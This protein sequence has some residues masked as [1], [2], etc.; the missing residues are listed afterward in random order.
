MC[1]CVCVCVCVCARFYVY[2]C[3]SGQVSYHFLH[4][5]VRIKLK[6]YNQSYYFLRFFSKLYLCFENF[7]INRIQI[8]IALYKYIFLAYSSTFS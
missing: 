2:V 5:I 3:M 6:G 4:K 8:W 7:G 1:V